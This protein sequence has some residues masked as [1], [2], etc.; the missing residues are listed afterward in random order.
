MEKGTVD[1]EL[2]LQL[3]M[4]GGNVTRV[5][6]STRDLTD[7]SDPS[8][9]LHTARIHSDEKV[10]YAAELRILGSTALQCSN[11]GEES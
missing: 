6:V 1:M 3:L 10:M 2:R 11:S 8:L 7:P 5:S 4:M 9:K